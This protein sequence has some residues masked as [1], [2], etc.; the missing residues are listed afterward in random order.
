MFQDFDDVVHKAYNEFISL[1]WPYK[2]INEHDMA[3]RKYEHWM[4]LKKTMIK[5]RENYKCGVH[6]GV[7]KKIMMMNDNRTNSV[8]MKLICEE[9]H[10]APLTEIFTVS[11]QEFSELF[12]KIYHHE[13]F[14][15]KNR[16]V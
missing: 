13:L 11:F 7:P 4:A 14:R 5:I 16:M 12:Q 8:V 15:V 6:C 2:N 1:S 9:E 3:Y 10:Q